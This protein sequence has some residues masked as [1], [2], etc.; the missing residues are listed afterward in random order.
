MRNRLCSTAHN[1]LE[2]EDEGQIDLEDY[3]KSKKGVIV[4]MSHGII[5][6]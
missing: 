5:K 3:L 6:E 2:N 4:V 1:S